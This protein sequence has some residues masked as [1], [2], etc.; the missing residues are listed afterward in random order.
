MQIKNTSKSDDPHSYEVIEAVTNKA[1]KKIL[2]LQRDWKE[3][4]AFDLLLVKA[5]N[6]AAAWLRYENHWEAFFVNNN[7]F[8]LILI[9]PV[10]KLVVQITFLSKCCALK[11]RY[12]ASLIPDTSSDTTLELQYN[13]SSAF[14][15]LSTGLHFWCPERGGDTPWNLKRHN[16]RSCYY[17]HTCM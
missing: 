7:V 4:F 8:F 16:V 6:W 1:Q 5:V 9:Q 13:T 10:H 2:R 11:S 14:K 3:K 12:T 15:K 17:C